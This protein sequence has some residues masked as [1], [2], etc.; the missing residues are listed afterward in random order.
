MKNLLAA[1]LSG[2][3]FGVGLNVGG[4]TQT[5]RIVGVM[6]FF[7]TWDPTLMIVLVAAVVTFHVCY[8]LIVPRGAPLF[9][10]KFQIPTRKDI[11]GR[12]VLGSGMFG[13]GWGLS[14]FCPGPAV[15]SLSVGQS[16]TIIVVLA[17]AAGM[18]LYGLVPL[19]PR[20]LRGVPGEAGD[21]P[22]H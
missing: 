22:S 2:T 10:A 11:T 21:S 18:L 8:R 3:L 1:L 6:D 12:L 15:A 5:S 4:M 9:A 20:I 14:G 13:V 19:V 7:G 17:I 16:Q